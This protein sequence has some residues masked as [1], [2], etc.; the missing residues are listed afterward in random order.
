[1]SSR[2]ANDRIQGEFL[3]EKFEGKGGWTFVRVP[4]VAMDGSRPF[5]MVVVTGS[6]DHVA[7]DRVKLM[8]YGDG[9]LFLPVNTKLRKALKKAAGEAVN[10]ELRPDRESYVLPNELQECLAYESEQVQRAFNALSSESREAFAK[11]VYQAQR[12]S[13]QAERIA[14]GFTNLES[15]L[16]LMAK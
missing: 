7:L 2:E 15:G 5:G 8:P 13:I 9:T 3:I 4:Q 6:I 10:L 14:R 1:M 16:P 11:W 12:K